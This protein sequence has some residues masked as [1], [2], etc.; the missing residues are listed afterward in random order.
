MGKVRERRVRGMAAVEAVIKQRL[1][2]LQQT[3]ET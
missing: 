1:V 2:K 3:E